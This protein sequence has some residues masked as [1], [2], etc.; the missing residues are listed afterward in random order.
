MNIPALLNRVN[1]IGTGVVDR[2]NTVGTNVL[3]KVNDAYV[4]LDEAVNRVRSTGMT[5]RSGAVSQKGTRMAG[6]AVRHPNQ[7]Q[8]KSIIDK[9]SSYAKEVPDQGLIPVVPSAMHPMARTATGYAKSLAGPL[10]K[11]FRVLTPEGTKEFYQDTID[12]ADYTPGTDSSNGS[13]TFNEHIANKAEY[14]RL[15]GSFMN[16]DYGRYNAEVLRNGQV[17][18]IDDYDTNRDVGWHARIALTGKDEKGKSKNITD[19]VISAASAPHRALTDIGW[20]NLR[21][22][23]NEYSIGR[24]DQ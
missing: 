19:R 17:I 20:T 3:N 15:G 11:P 16:K 22:F 18:P 10:G 9:I 24:K 12:A 21:P 5:N 23:G 8:E 13:I 7:E 6:P 1:E 14:D 4:N 2:F